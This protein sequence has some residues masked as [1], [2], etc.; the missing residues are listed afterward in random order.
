M[1]KHLE[2]TER[3]TCEFCGLI[4]TALSDR[5]CT[6]RHFFP[7]VTNNYYLIAEEHEGHF[8]SGR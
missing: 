1:Q 6:L 5:E 7:T 2:L 8:R 3:S 4:I